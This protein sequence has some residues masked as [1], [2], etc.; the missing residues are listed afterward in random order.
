MIKT[1][2]KNYKCA[3]NDAINGCVTAAVSFI[4]ATKNESLLT[5]AK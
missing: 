2:D 5:A 3:F 4:E 1:T